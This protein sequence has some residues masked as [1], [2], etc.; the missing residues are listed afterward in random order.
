[1]AAVASEVAFGRTDVTLHYDR[2]ATIPAV[3]LVFQAG[4]R[5]SF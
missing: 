2:V 5:A 4:V 1:V 3:R